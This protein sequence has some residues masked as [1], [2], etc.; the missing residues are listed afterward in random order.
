MICDHCKFKTCV[1]HKLPWHE[2]QSCDEFDV[3]DSQIERLEQE[4]ATAKLLA[5]DSRICPACKE[6]VV[7]SDGCDHMQCM[8]RN[9]S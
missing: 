8:Y 7:R 2:G 1:K 9:I 4:E 3:D 6:C 5:K